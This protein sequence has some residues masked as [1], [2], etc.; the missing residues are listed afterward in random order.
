VAEAR[1]AFERCE[2]ALQANDIPV[3]EEMFW[4][5]PATT[6]YV[7]ARTSL[8]GSRFPISAAAAYSAASGA[9]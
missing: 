8:A 9:T 2:E 6:R 5:H 1:A 7:W 3:L 4:N